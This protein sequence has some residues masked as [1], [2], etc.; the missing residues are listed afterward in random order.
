[1]PA[2]PTFIP[3]SFSHFPGTKPTTDQITDHSEAKQSHLFTLLVIRAH[4]PLV[5]VM[6]NLF[7]PVFWLPSSEQSGQGYNSV[8]RLFHA[9]IL[10]LSGTTY[11]DNILS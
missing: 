3:D 5:L 7:M 1:V 10:L 2:L 11:R 8:G 9:S 6:V 4:P